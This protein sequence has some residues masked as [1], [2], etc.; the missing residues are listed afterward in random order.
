M[1]CPHCVCIYVMNS[2]TTLTWCQVELSLDGTDNDTQK[3]PSLQQILLR[4]SHIVL[5]LCLIGL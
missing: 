3:L 2:S 4:P 5:C 1:V